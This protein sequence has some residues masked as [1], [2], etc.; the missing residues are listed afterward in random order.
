MCG[1]LQSQICV[2]DAKLAIFMNVKPQS[3]GV[4]NRCKQ[5]TYTSA[6]ALMT[7]NDGAMYQV[8]TVM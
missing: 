1:Y 7:I 8:H 2:E 5:V 4:E 3:M 6:K